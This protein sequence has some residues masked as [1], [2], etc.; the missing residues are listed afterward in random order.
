VARGD[1]FKFLGRH[2]EA[3][4]ELESAGALYRAVNDEVGWA[5]TRIG[6]LFLSTRLNR[7]TETLAEAEQA[8][9]I[10]ITHQQ[11]ELRLRLDLNSA[12][13]FSSIGDRHRAG[14]L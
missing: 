7:V 6:R 4:D 12:L 2:Q 3:W 14:V 9:E 10:F 1:A 11:A 5:R 13:V 8:S